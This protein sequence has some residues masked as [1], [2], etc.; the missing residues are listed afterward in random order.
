MNFPYYPVS[1]R[2]IF[3]LFVLFLFFHPLA[4][5]TPVQ[6]E[7]G[8]IDL[9]QWDFNSRQAVINGL[10]LFSEGRF[11][12]P[13]K[14]D[15]ETVSF[16]SVVVPSRWELENGPHGYGTFKLTVLLPE[17]PQL[18][19]LELGYICWAYRLYIDGNE[20]LK[21]GEPGRTKDEE[22]IQ[23]W[24]GKISFVGSGSVEILIHVS[25]FH[26]RK[27]GIANPIYLGLNSMLERERELSTIFLFFSLGIAFFIG[28]FYISFYFFRKKE[29]YALHFGLFS[30][31]LLARVIMLRIDGLKSTLPFLSSLSFETIAKLDYLTNFPLL[32]GFVIFFFLY[33]NIPL[34]K[35][36]Y[37]LLT[38]ILTVLYI[39]MILVFPYHIYNNGLIFFQIYIFGSIAYVFRVMILKIRTS[40]IKR[41]GLIVSYVILCFCVVIDIL[42]N[43]D[44]V[45][46]ST[47]FTFHTGF[48]FFVVTQ[49]FFI[50]R[51]FSRAMTD[52][53][54]LSDQLNLLLDERDRTQLILEEKVDER[55]RTLAKAKLD[56]E[57]ANRSKSEFLARMSHEIRTPMNAISGF[58]HLLS[59]TPETE[60]RKQFSRMIVDESDKLLNIVNELLDIS[61]IDAGKM[62]LDMKSFC[63]NQ[64]MLSIAAFFEP[65]FREKGLE[66]HTD[67][68]IRNINVIGDSFRLRQVLVNLLGNALKFTHSGGVTLTVNN[69]KELENEMEFYFAVEDTGIGI[70]AENQQNIFKDFVQV[71]TSIARKYG[72][73]GLGTSIAKS[74]VEM[75]GG[76]I[77]LDS[78]EGE[79]TVFWF[80]LCFKLD[81]EVNKTGTISENHSIPGELAELKVLVVEDYL[82]NQQVA[83]QYLEYAGCNVEIAEN[84]KEAIAVF[85]SYKPDLIF[86]DLH[87]PEMDGL[88]ATRKIRDLPGGRL[89][90][91]FGLTADPLDD[92]IESCRS[93]GMDDVLIKPIRWSLFLEALIKG[94]KRA[95]SNRG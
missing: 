80:N 62:N 37:L 78:R 68:F 11:L 23:G 66:F 74:L 9:R 77:H 91:I 7:S 71:D 22:T 46:S 58:G 63:L 14:D 42:S 35:N 60:K 90:P 19:A 3:I 24:L 54:M 12:S 84:G 70:P 87:M 44:L 32:L 59:L 64:E 30:L 2:I 72:G 48:F 85:N 4:A 83:R 13:H 92:T 29:K 82:A 43:L 33:L 8:I 27:G 26:A 76:G 94:Q 41:P 49:A 55:T 57:N 16:E 69:V 39:L 51:T 21:V 93:S 50:I 31:L 89:I 25:N 36:N 79:G 5:E 75:M 53:E 47:L 34:K 73:S 95:D 17:E 86:M 56:A 18:M 1:S 20:V 10:W 67:F 6:T 52:S 45:P 38:R 15:R 61:K 65:Q 40:G 88:E 28:V 81:L